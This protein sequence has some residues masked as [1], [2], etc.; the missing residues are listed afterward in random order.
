MSIEIMSKDGKVRHTIRYEKE[1]NLVRIVHYDIITF[2]DATE[3]L[4]AVEKL[5]EGKTPRL[6]LDDSSNVTALKMDKETREVF[7]QV[8]SRIKLDKNAVFGADPMT[9]MMSKIIFT[10]AGQAKSTKFFKTEEE[11]VKWLREK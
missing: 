3:M 8:G 5:L 4:A 1:N 7:K 9:R 10:V 11:A 2:Q 6:L